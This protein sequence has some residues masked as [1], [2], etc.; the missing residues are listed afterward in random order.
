MSQQKVKIEISETNKLSD[1]PQEWNEEK[2]EG[3]ISKDERTILPSVGVQDYA[4]L[5]PG[6]HKLVQLF[7]VL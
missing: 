1:K 4:H 2:N 5:E 3:E 7:H 6:V